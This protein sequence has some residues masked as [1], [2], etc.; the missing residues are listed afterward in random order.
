MWLSFIAKRS[1]YTGTQ[2]GTTVGQWVHW[3]SGEAEPIASKGMS[4]VRGGSSRLRPPLQ[5][6]GAP[7]KE[8]G[9]SGAAV[10]PCLLQHSRASRAGWQ[11]GLGGSS[12]HAANA[13]C[14]TCACAAPACCGRLAVR[15]CAWLQAWRAEHSEQQ[16]GRFQGRQVH[17]PALHSSLQCP[18]PGSAC[19]TPAED[20]SPTAPAL[21]T[22]EVV[23][24]GAEWENV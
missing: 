2:L 15:R 16:R 10:P 5:M 8:K 7:A 24:A 23:T 14:A 6:Q 3:G 17:C 18:A 9:G 4:R 21:H 13:L 1:K 19:P 20:G 12:Q 22:G 11:A